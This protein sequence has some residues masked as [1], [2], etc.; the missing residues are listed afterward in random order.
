MAQ[1]G[2]GGT[3]H[4]LHGGLASHA[5]DGAGDSSRKIMSKRSVNDEA[6]RTGVAVGTDGN[7]AKDKGV[8]K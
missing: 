6:V 8:L 4:K 2:I 7:C 1:K 3:Q 5:V